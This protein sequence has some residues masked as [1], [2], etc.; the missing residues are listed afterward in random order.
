MVD[1]ALHALSLLLLAAAAAKL[2]S[3]A[4][5]VD[6]L[7]QARLPASPVLVRL[8]AVAE[9][10]VAVLVL[11]VG[12]PWPALALAA[13]HLGFAA[14]V[15]RLR[16]VA[17]GGAPCGCFGAAEAPA[18]RLHVIANLAAAAVAGLG[19]AAGADALLP[20]LADQPALGLPYL[21]LVVVA[22]QAMLLLL[23]ALPDLLV[24]DRQLA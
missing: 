14:F 12:G 4:R 18:D 22:A 2:V 19:A 5:S 17:G 23:T 20:T 8:L 13:L 6:A 15:A 9:G 3:P 16:A 10:T 24:A 1:G 11:V 7:R 21:A